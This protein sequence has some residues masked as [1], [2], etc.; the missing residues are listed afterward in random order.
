MVPETLFEFSVDMD[1]DIGGSNGSVGILNGN[2]NLCT[3]FGVSGV[4]PIGIGGGFSTDA[5]ASSILFLITM[6]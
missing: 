2:L 1:M 5:E 6:T 3:V 4:R